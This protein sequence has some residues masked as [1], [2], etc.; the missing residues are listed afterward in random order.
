MTTQHVTNVA[1]GEWTDERNPGKTFTWAQGTCSCG[2]EGAEV[3]TDKEGGWSSVLEMSVKAWAER[4]ARHHRIVA[5][6]TGHML[7]STE[8]IL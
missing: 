3:T 2:W 6:G 7:L 8:A 5:T 1:H 4:Q